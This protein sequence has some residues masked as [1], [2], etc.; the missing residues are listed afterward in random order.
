M[1]KGNQIG[2]GKRVQQRPRMREPKEH[3]GD[4]KGNGS[5]DNL[6][7]PRDERRGQGRM[8]LLCVCHSVVYEK[9]ICKKKKQHHPSFSCLAAS[10]DSKP[11]QINISMEQ[12]VVCLCVFNCV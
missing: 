2:A 7:G 4:E 11:T 6:N 12:E 10:A 1:N 5:D 8:R 9:A 3:E